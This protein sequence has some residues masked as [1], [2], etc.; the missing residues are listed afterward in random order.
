MNC[1][2]ENMDD[3]KVLAEF[4]IA[5]AQQDDSVSEKLDEL[6]AVTSPEELARATGALLADG[7][8][9]SMPGA[10]E[11]VSLL[12]D[13]FDQ[14]WEMLIQA[15]ENR[16]D[17][18]SEDKLAAVVLLKSAGRLPESGI[19]GELAEKV[20]ELSEI[21][22]EIQP[23]LRQLLLAGPD[24]ALP[25]LVSIGEMTPQARRE[26]FHDLLDTSDPQLNQSL[27]EILELPSNATHEKISLSNHFNSFSLS[28]KIDDLLTCSWVTDLSA[29][30][31]FGAGVDFVEDGDV[32]HR[33]ILGGSWQKGIRL[34]EYQVADPNEGA[35]QV[36]LEPPRSVCSHSTL[37]KKWMIELL[38]KGFSGDFKSSAEV[39]T[40]GYLDKKLVF[41][42]DVDSDTW[43]A[44]QRILVEH[45]PLDL[46]PDS[47]AA[48]A[49]ILAP[50]VRHW[51]PA[52]EQSSELISEF[53]ARGKRDL[54]S[55]IGQSILRVY[56]ER[57]LGPR[58]AELI[59]RLS[60]MSFF[61]LARSETELENQKELMALARAS[62]RLAMDL[63]DPSRVVPGHPFI[64]KI[65]EIVLL[66]QK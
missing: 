28:P 42:T 41:W 26:I 16:P 8:A 57:S 38:S 54:K 21:G 61:W 55:E 43:A 2:T 49:A 48:D 37:V 4:L 15:I 33:F 27:F 18:S 17:I 20:S 46:R 24:D 5:V 62:A 19:C 12:A 35:M 59:K 6:I 30:G 7:P 66:G 14:L 60:A 58:I 50:A 39:W 11:L 51:F 34:F 3:S 10:I 32:I 47:L 31:Q 45:N 13:R 40:S 22:S 9:Q 25:L 52:D 56:F 1:K 64:Q 44:W 36:R 29:A 63:A 53:Q 65:A 23:Q